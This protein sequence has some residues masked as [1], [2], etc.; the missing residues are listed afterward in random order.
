MARLARSLIVLTGLVLLGGSPAEAKKRAKPA[1]E[2]PAGDDA[3]AAD[4]SAAPSAA[5]AGDAPAEAAP[6]SGTPGEVPAATDPDPA[7]GVPAVA[8]EPEPPALPRTYS[9]GVGLRARLVSVP[10]WLLGVFT[11]KNVPLLT[12]GHFGVEGFFRRRNFDI[13]V[14]FSYQNMSPHDGNWLGTGTDPDPNTYAAINTD[15]VRFKGFSLYALDISFIWHQMFTSWLGMHYGAGIGAA[16]IA[17]K[18]LHN[19]SGY[20]SAG[21][22]LPPG[23]D[24]ACTEAN[25]GDVTKC[26]PPNVT[27]ANGTCTPEANLSRTE[28]AYSVPPA[29]PIVNVVL[30]LDFRVPSLR[31]WEAKVEGGFYD[32]FFFGGTVSY[33]F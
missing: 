22:T 1:A 28:Q 15:Y 26:H 27:C 5:A 17:G 21:N 9:F 29:I 23:A 33:T 10:G 7:A 3:A 32:A 12:F 25:A 20:D 24:G 16:Y 30:G 18:I 13:A 8:A 31:G 11:K 4:K 2:Q 14:S 6:A 19:D